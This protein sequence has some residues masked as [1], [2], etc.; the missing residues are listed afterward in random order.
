MKVSFLLFQK[1]NPS[2][3]SDPRKHDLRNCSS[4][5]CA[6]F[7]ISF[8][9][10][11]LCWVFCFLCFTRSSL[12]LFSFYWCE[13]ATRMFFRFLFGVVLGTEEPASHCFGV[14]PTAS[15]AWLQI[16][17]VQVTKTIIELCWQ[18]GI[19]SGHHLNTRVYKKGKQRW[20]NGRPIW[21]YEKRGI[22]WL[23]S[24]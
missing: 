24:G 8:S 6:I 14:R 4:L 18:C 11:P 12:S 5:T 10:G 9:F 3:F 19:P 13:F 1:K 16:P 17:H 23:S 21:K 15:T 20:G 2:A 22:P 7:C